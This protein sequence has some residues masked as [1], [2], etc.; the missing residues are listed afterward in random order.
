[1]PIKSNYDI[2]I[3]LE[4]KMLDLKTFVL[5]LVVFQ[6]YSLPYQH[7]SFALLRETC[8]VRSNLTSPPRLSRNTG[9]GKLKAPPKPPRQ[10]TPRR[11]SGL[12]GP[13]NSPVWKRRK[14]YILKVSSNF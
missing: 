9:E 8:N 10:K 7:D 4:I 14:Q 13:E 2:P 11:K 12:I 3:T 1:M 6:D 5:V